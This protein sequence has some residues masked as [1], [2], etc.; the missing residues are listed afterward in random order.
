MEPSKNYHQKIVV[1]LIRHGARYPKA[2]PKGWPLCEISEPGALTEKGAQQAEELGQ[3]IKE[4]YKI[5]QDKFDMQYVSTESS[6]TIET[7][8]NFIRGVVGKEATV[9]DST[10]P[11]SDSPLIEIISKKEDHILKRHRQPEAKALK[12]EVE[13]SE[14]FQMKNL[15]T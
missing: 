1:L 8:K 11:K 9:M 7:A 13:Q 10:Q 2:I 12:Q 5:D 15:E 6:R 14:D 4:K 3:R